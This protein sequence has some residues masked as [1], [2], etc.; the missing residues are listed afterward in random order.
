MFLSVPGDR[1]FFCLLFFPQQRFFAC[2][3][4]EAFLPSP[5]SH[6]S[7]KFTI[8]PSVALCFCFRGEKG[9]GKQA[10]L[11]AYPPQPSAT[12]LPPGLERRLCQSPSLPQW[13]LGVPSGGVVMKNSQQKR[14]YWCLGAPAVLNRHADPSLASKNLLTL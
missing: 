7:R 11:C 14:L 8:L 4:G 2:L 5:R 3:L 13:F 1:G 9:P 6:G 10:G 12:F